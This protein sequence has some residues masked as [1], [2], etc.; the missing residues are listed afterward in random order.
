MRATFSLRHLPRPH[1]P[2]RRPGKRLR[3]LRKLFR[4][5]RLMRFA[6]ALRKIWAADKLW[7]R[8]EMRKGLD[9]QIA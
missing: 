6:W 3:K 4:L 2:E 1:S 7:Q 9:N 8:L 5:R